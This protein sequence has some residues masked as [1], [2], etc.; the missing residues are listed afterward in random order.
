MS[1]TVLEEAGRLVAAGEPFVLAT[2]VW[3][4]GPSSG[5]QGAKAII[6]RSGGLQGWLGGACAEPTVVREALAALGDGRS[7]LLLLGPPEEFGDRGGDDDAISVPMACESEG[8]ME[9]YL[10]PVL[11]KPRIVAI[12]RSPAVAAL[13]RLAA[14]IGWPAAVID[15]DALDLGDVDERTFVVVATQGHFDEVALEAALGTSAG[16]VGLVASRKRADSI[17]EHLRSRGQSGEALARVRAPAGLDLGSLDPEEMAVAI[18]AEIVGLAAAGL[19]AGVAVA[20]PQQA[21]D[22]RC[23][24]SVDVST[25][26]HVLERDGE[27]YYFCGAGCRI[28]F[29]EGAG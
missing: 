4:R 23:G 17:L 9:V 5:R 8:A 11:P 29:E 12:G 28:A 10:E 21:I 19:A 27:T 7:R 24:M 16:Y 6:G 22:P 14:A 2:V 25:A 13:A 1:G 20:V 3:R 15:D 26:R 18:L